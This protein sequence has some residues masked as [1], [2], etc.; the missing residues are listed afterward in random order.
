MNDNIIT[1]ADHYEVAATSSNNSLDRLD[2][3]ASNTCEPA[4]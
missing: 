3:M 4:A 1:A 2:T